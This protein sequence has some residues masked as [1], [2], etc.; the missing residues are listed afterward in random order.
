MPSALE[1]PYRAPKPTVNG[2]HLPSIM[3]TDI[4][5]D[6]FCHGMTAFWRRM[7]DET[8]VFLAEI[9]QL[10]LQASLSTLGER[11]GRFSWT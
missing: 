10:F 2:A 8:D 11:V 9:W 1:G 7:V 5:R 3:H 6:E 4:G